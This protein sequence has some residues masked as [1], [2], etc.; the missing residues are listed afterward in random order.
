MHQIEIGNHVETHQVTIVNANRETLSIDIFGHVEEV[1]TRD[2]V[3]FARALTFAYHQLEGSA[4]LIDKTGRAILKLTF[5]R[6]QVDVCIVRATSVR[7][8]QTDQSY[9]TSV[10]AQIGIVE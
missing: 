4:E 2:Y 6:G 5:K 8:F 1:K 3:T 9:V 10:L 7:T